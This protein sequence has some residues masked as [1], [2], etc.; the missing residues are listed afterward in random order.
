MEEA[1]KHIEAVLDQKDKGMKLLIGEFVEQA[2][3]MTQSTLGY[4][5][6]INGA[7]DTLVMIGWSKGAM[8]N[9]AVIDKPIVYQLSETG[10]WGDAVRERQ[11]V[12]TNDYANTEKPTKKGYPKGHVEVT[13]HFNVPVFEGDHIAAVFG[14]G[15]KKS[16][17]TDQDVANLQHF[18]NEL[19]TTVKKEVPNELLQ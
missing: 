15:N 3:K 6:V 11:P 17:Y 8:Q 2:V 7:E 9:C 14:V 13:R 10:L 16:A 5:A 12:V 18:T 4:F 19:W 1:K